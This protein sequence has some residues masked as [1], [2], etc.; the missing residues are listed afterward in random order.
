MWKLNQITVS[1]TGALN[2]N[3]FLQIQIDPTTILIPALIIL[4][5]AT[6]I[7]QNNLAITTQILIQ[8]L[9]I[10]RQAHPEVEGPQVLLVEEEVV[11][12]KINAYE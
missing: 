7:I 9:V 6:T 5:L 8:D 2:L 11:L 10:I 3:G 12:I 4:N 1:L